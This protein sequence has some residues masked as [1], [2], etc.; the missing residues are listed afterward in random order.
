MLKTANFKLITCLIP[1]QKSI[2]ILDKLSTEYNIIMA[3]KSNARGSS[4][5]SDVSWIEME[6]LEVIV[7]AEQADEVYEY[8]FDETEIN[9]P[10]GG[11][12]FQHALSRSSSYT[13]PQI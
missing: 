8:L 13:L 11:L 6:V 12:I 4:F 9:A 2:H 10:H 1:Q 7:S 5:M 3:N